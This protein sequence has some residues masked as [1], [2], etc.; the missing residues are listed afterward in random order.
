ME[1]WGYVRVSTDAEQQAAGWEDQFR[2]L[3]EQGVDPDK[4]RSEEVSTRG[5]RPVFENMLA[6]ANR[7][8]TPE[9][10]ICIVAAKM[11][12]AFRDIAAADAAI[13]RPVNRN[14]IWLLPDLSKTPLDPE[15]PTQMLLVRMMGA[16]AQFERDRMAERRAY[17]IAKA[18][19]DGKYKGRAP[20]ARAKT[21]EVLGLKARG[22]KPDHI[23]KV[24]G[25]SR[26]SVYRILKDISG[27]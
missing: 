21:D 4:I 23:A 19:R 15:D 17:G 14:V 7:V 18:K 16:V 1:R 12:R 11:D 20:T 13:T 5:P 25:I 6:E 8:A 2:V 9:R 22:Y 27:T 26:A 10:R 24:T 3:R